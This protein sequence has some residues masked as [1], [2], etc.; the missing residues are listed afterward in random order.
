MTSPYTLTRLA[1]RGW[2]RLT[3]RPHIKHLRAAC[4]LQQS[5]PRRRRWELVSFSFT[6]RRWEWLDSCQEAWRVIHLLARVFPY[7]FPDPMNGYIRMCILWVLIQGGDG[8]ST[9][10]VNKRDS[11]G[12]RVTLWAERR[13]N[14][15]LWQG[16]KWK[17]I[18]FVNVLIKA[19]NQSV[20]NVPAGSES[21]L[22][23]VSLP[24]KVKC[25]VMERTLV[26]SSPERAGKRSNPGCSLDLSRCSCMLVM[27]RWHQQQSASPSL[28]PPGRRSA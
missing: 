15:A 13:E 22:W 3:A 25:N 12:S 28:Q 1:W 5:E 26:C 24:V 18:G 11:G 14:T 20:R 16:V 9:S 8:T 27:S 19:K 7:V 23:K 4:Q 21:N 2:Q 17:W 10:L 6:D